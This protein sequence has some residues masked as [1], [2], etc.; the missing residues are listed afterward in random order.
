MA[1]SDMYAALAGL[2]AAP[3]Y[4]TL[5]IVLGLLEPGFS[6]RTSLMSLLGGVPGL[7]GVVFNA[8]VAMTGVMIIVF[9]IGLRRQLPG[10]RWSVVGFGL[11]VVGGLG[12]LGAA[13]FS[14]NQ[15]CENVLQA[16]D[17]VGR[18]HLASSL[19]AGAGTSLAP[20]F[21]WAAMRASAKW[22]RFA[23]PTLAAGILANLPGLTLWITLFAGYRLQSVEGLL[24]RVG[25]V[26]ILIR[27]A[28]LAV[29]MLRS[30]SH[31]DERRVRG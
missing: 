29:H 31:E 6:H 15:G 27:I 16:P 4:L 9:A 14:C 11:L 5:I 24:Q 10:L 20:F 25:F 30:A 13:V 8:G 23:A 26:V 17:F 3:F 12:L 7:R 22:S 1:K 18:A 19:F 2:A 28:S 21:L